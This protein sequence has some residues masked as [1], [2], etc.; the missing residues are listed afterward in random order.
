[1]RKSLLYPR[2]AL[3]NLKKNK[4]LYLP[5]LLA[6]MG[7]V[8]MFC[9]LVTLNNDPALDD[10]ASVRSILSLGIIVVGIFSAI[11]LFYTNSVLTKQR[12]REFGLYNMLGMEKRHI[13]FVLLYES[14]Y[15]TLLA[16]AGGLVA[17]VVFS[18]LLQLILLKLLGGIATFTLRIDPAAIG[19][20]AVLFAIIFFV[21]YLNTVRIIRFAK[22]VD[23]LHGSSEGEREPKSKWVLA[24]AGTVCMATGYILSV[25]TN[26]AISAIGLFFVAVLF[27]IAGTYL[28]FTAFSIVLLKALRRNKNYYYK[29][30]HFATVSGMLYRMKRNAAGLASICIL[31]T[32]VLVTVSTTVCL[33]LGVSDTVNQMHPTDISVSYIGDVTADKRAE[34][35]KLAYEPAENLGRTVTDAHEYWKLEF[36][37]QR[38]GN[39]LALVDAETNQDILASTASMVWITDA[40]SYE[41]LT[42]ETTT[43]LPGQVL[44]WSDGAAVGDTVEMLGTTYSVK[45]LDSFPVSG[46]YQSLNIKT[47]YLVVD[48]EATLL[49]IE[50]QEQQVYFNS[51]SSVDYTITY[52]I[53]GTSEEKIACGD[54]VYENLHQQDGGF[55]F[56]DREESYQNAMEMYGALFFIGMFLGFLFLL[57]TVLI[58]YY[59]Q[60]SE[61]YDD[62]EKF[63][64]MQKVGMT[65]KEVKATI[66]S[67]VL[68][69]FFLPLVTAAI[70]IAFAFPMIKWIL[71]ALGM[72]NVSLF[73]SCTVG[74]LLI[75]AVIYTAVYLLTSRAYYSIV[76]DS[77]N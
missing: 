21:I 25:M 59:K 9:V 47:V 42:G 77:D 22:P 67:Q 11:I 36:A 66:H 71:R 20:T 65:P 32:M 57:A 13:G 18:K 2:L 31:S 55:S 26:S 1:M 5:Y 68:I 49:N 38:Q 63:A 60:V 76:S 16:L 43:V 41:N 45:Q 12:K 28:L 8:M 39:E 75:F 62:R 64:I 40:A 7:T 46:G 37:V 19:L 29:T 70:H 17:S 51:G 34:L 72:M 61:G 10:N 44:A 48:S 15:T 69:V 73:V 74:S 27:V 54:A 4:R 33:Y 3:T 56:S 35:A 58:I 52:N 14:L 50:Q 6:C 53:D 24:I 23:L 30:K